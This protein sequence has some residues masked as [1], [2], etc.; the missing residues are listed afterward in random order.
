MVSP[1]LEIP[2]CWDMNV[3]NVFVFSGNVTRSSRTS[4]DMPLLILCESLRRDRGFV[5]ALLASFTHTRSEHPCRASTCKCPHA[6]MV[7]SSPD[8]TLMTRYP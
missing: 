1:Q 2:V 3:G 7:P 6:Q 8:V 4:R 5:G